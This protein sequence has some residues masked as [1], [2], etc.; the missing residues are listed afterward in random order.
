MKRYETPRRTRPLKSTTRISPSS[1][2]QWRSPGIGANGLPRRKIRLQ[3]MQT[4]MKNWTSYAITA[5]IAV[6]A[7]WA[8][9]SFVA[10]KTGLP[11]A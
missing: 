4:D 1:F 2:R 10:P 5:V 9:N 3:K 8:Y 11:T 6:L 7:V